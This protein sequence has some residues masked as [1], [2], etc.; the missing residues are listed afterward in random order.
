MPVSTSH[1][2]FSSL[3]HP[4]AWLTVALLA[5][6]SSPAVAQERPTIA[7]KTAGMEA[8]DGFVPLYWDSDAGTLWMEIARFDSELLYIRSL[9][10]G[11]GSNDIGLDRGQLGASA[12]V[13]FERVGPKVLMVQPNQRFRVESNNP[14]EVRALE[15]AFATSVL[16]GFTVEAE[17][18]GTVLVDVGFG[19]GNPTQPIWLREGGQEIVNVPGSED[20]EGKPHMLRLGKEEV[21]GNEMWV[22]DRLVHAPDL[23]EG[24]EYR[25]F[26]AF[27]IMNHHV[28]TARDSFFSYVVFVGMSILSEDGKRVVGD[29]VLFNNHVKKKMYGKLVEERELKSEKER[30]QVLEEWFGIKLNATE[31]AGIKGLVTALK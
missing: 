5:G 17:T 15:E 21:E 2:A 6:A 11:V 23:P 9:A 7:E 25:P 10:A 29:M 20:G 28:S 1:I 22:L 30:I 19:G 26:Y 8:L 13:R 3:R 24:G 4:R 31:Q 18:D 12:V 14:D 27:E 16:W